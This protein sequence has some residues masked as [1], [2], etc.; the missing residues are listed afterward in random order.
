MLLG[1][2]MIR[3]LLKVKCLAAKIYLQ[4]YSK[5]LS[6]ITVVNDKSLGMYFNYIKQF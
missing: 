6:Y 4:R 3:P 5:E 2:I 1:T